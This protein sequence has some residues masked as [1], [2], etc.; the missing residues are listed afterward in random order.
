MMN[1]VISA[2]T[3]PFFQV[4]GRLYTVGGMEFESLIDLVNYYM[5]HPLY[6]KIKLLHP[7][8]REAVKRMGDL[9]LSDGG[10]DNGHESYMNP[11]T[12]ENQ[13]IT[14]KALYDYKAQ[15]D[16]ELSFCKHAIITN[17]DKKDQMWWQGDYGG[18]KQLYFPANY[19]VEINVTNNF[20]DADATSSENLMLGNLQKGSLDVHGA[21]VDVITGNGELEWILRIQNPTMPNCFEVGVQTKEE[22]I[23]WM[24]AIKAAAQNASAM[25]DQRKK[26]ERHS[27]VAKEIS[28]LIIYCRSVPF[29][30]AAW[31]FYEMSSFPETKAEK[32]FLQQDSKLFLHYHR[33][34]ISRVYPKGQRLDSSNYTPTA[35]WNVGC[36]MVALNYQTPDKPMQLNQAKFRDNGGCG[37]VLK[38]DFLFRDDYDL[39]DAEP[40]LAGVKGRSL[41]VQIIGARH[42]GKNGRNIANPLVEIEV[43]GMPYDQGTKHKTCSVSDNGFNPLWNES[44]EFHVKNPDLSMLRFEVQDE[45]MFG[46]NNFLG[47]AVFPLRC[48]RMGYRSVPLKN[49]YSED[50]E[51]AALLVHVA[52]VN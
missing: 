16:D 21:V 5:K 47:Q 35:F 34:Q 27:R 15:H 45:D 10:T 31:Q 8:S 17:V 18:K 33:N 51:L 9:S 22:A 3:L 4:E 37:Y 40:S 12:L 48:I 1:N 32:L 7:I 50:L 23:E 46:E 30:N 41:R 13:Q 20:G 44:C 19:V 52:Y 25:E 29:K 36:Q 14:V 38:P 11:S 49:K 2:F 26:L 24:D 28:D 6:R 43:I 42:L 39:T